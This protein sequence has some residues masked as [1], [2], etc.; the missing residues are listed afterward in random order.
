MPN[1]VT[2]HQAGLTSMRTSPGHDRTA[3]STPGQ[4]IHRLHQLLTDAGLDRMLIGHETGV[5]VLSVHSELTIWCVNGRITWRHSTDRHAPTAIHPAIDPHGAAERLL[6]HLTAG[7]DEPRPQEGAEP[8]NTSLE[9]NSQGKE[10]A[11]GAPSH[12]APS[13]HGTNETDT[14]PRRTPSDDSRPGPGQ[15]AADTSTAS[16]PSPPEERW[17]VTMR[18]VGALPQE[19]KRLNGR[20]ATPR[21]ED[22]TRRGRLDPAHEH[23]THPERRLGRRILS[24]SGHGPD[25]PTAVGQ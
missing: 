1:D 13:M 17:P 5:S 23:E 16:A 21:E 19:H 22:A 3:P 12:D 9:S 14:R 24:R 15:E 20:G 10:P 2:R 25:L 6:D 18:I 11:D 8:D 7:T 4:T